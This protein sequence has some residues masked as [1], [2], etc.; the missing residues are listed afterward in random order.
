MRS[1]KQ[2]FT[3]QKNVKSLKLDFFFYYAVVIF[4]PLKI[5]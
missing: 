1:S 4:F 3:L 5:T 2:N